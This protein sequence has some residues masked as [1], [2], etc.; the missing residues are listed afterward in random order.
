MQYL[1][2]KPPP[3]N[4][5]LWSQGTAG[6]LMLDYVLAADFADPLLA[7]CATTHSLGVGDDPYS[8]VLLCLLS[9]CKA[10]KPSQAAI[11]WSNQGNAL[12]RD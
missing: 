6:C 12:M 7:P 3:S 5:D 2:E 10:G 11:M 4:P 9:A 8:F 1:K